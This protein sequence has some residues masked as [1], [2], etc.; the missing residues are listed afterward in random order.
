MSHH[1]ISDY[2]LLSDCHGSALV[3][4]AGS[5]DWLSMPRFDSPSIFARLLDPEGGHWLIRPAA[6]NDIQRQYID[7]TLVLETTFECAEGELTLCDCLAVGPGE[8]GHQIGAQSP[9][10]LLRQA[11]CTAG[12]VTL[13]FEYA[14]RPEYGLTQ[15]LLQSDEGGILA[16]GGASALLLSCSMQPDF[17]GSTA[18]STFTLTEGDTLRFALQYASRAESHPRRW[19]FDAIGERIDQTKHAWRTW[20]QMHRAYQGPWHE[21]V[22]HSGRILQALMYAPT[23]ALVA[24]PTTSLPETQGGE[25]NWDYRYTWVRDASMTLDALSVAACGNE[26]HRFFDFLAKTALMKLRGGNDMQIMYGIGGEHA[27]HEIE[28]EHLSGWR[29]SRPVRIGNAAWQQSQLDVFGELMSAATRAQSGHIELDE[30]NATFL[31][32]VADT[33]A[34]RWRE[35]DH[36]I[37]EARDEPRHYLYSKLMCWVTLERAI[38]LADELDAGRRLEDWTS[39]R[40]AI[41]ETILERGWSDSAGAYT[42][43]FGDEALDASNLTLAMLNFLPADDPKMLATI[44]AIEDRLTDERGLVYRYRTDDGLVGEEGPFLLCT[45]WLAQARARAGHLDRAREIFWR[46]ARFANDLGLLSE[47]V[48]ADCDELRGNFPQALSHIGLVNAARDIDRAQK[49]AE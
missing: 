18:R 16:Y 31:S 33:A 8:T 35:K 5:V 4:R 22:H 15:P 28:L 7:A 41:R 14:P 45:F 29:D 21:Q 26:A 9:H 27:L 32:Q 1:P 49:A 19:S 48:A 25:R 44:D 43:A 12:K 11:R 46:A 10:A 3:H 17:E 38:A 6:V 39:E 2:G 20:S 47:E 37:W 24:A 23:G 30:V 13:N 34:R 40:D 36:G 42:R